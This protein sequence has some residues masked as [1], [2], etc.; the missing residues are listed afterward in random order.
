MPVLKRVSYRKLPA[1]Q[2]HRQQIV[3]LHG[4]KR[5]YFLL[6]L[7]RK[8]LKMDHQTFKPSNFLAISAERLMLRAHS[9]GIFM[10]SAASTLPGWT[11]GAPALEDDPQ[12]RD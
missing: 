4:D 10:S 3:G 8:S 5:T 9:E 6:G 1:T 12:L 7:G 11:R 2:G